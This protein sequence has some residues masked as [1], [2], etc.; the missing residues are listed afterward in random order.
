M[1]VINFIANIIWVILGGIITF[2]GWAVIGALLCITIIG[3]PAGK[4]C[5]KFARLTLAPFGKKVDI[6]FSKHPVANVIWL[7]LVGWEMF[8]TYIVS[9]LLCMITIIGI[10]VGIQAFKISCLALAPFG[11]SVRKK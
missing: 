8:L 4:Q 2:I 3:I 5:F 6:N 9:A 1:K 7:L 10:P 11:A